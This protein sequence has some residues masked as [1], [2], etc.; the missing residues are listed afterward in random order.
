MTNSGRT[1][2]PQLRGR[3]R[4]YR[5]PPPG[6]GQTAVIDAGL[7]PTAPAFVACLGVA[8]YLEPDDV[9]ALACAVAALA[10]GSELVLDHALPAGD[11][12]EVGETY[13][14]GVAAVAAAAGEP[15][16][17]LL[18]SAPMATLLEQAGLVV[19]RATDLSDAVAPLLRHRTDSLRPVRVAGVVHARV[20]V[21]EPAR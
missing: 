16:R 12:D 3:A 10:P 4:T 9:R 14:R 11:R 18:G 19:E 15:W 1:R 21:S 17:C 20:P 6:H 5:P 7:D 13:A 8:M 2:K